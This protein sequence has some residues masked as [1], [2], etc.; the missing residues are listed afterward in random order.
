[1]RR[2]TLVS[3]FAGTAWAQIAGPMLGWVPDSAQIGPQIR[4]QIRPMYGL[5]GAGAVAGAIAS[6]HT[7]ALLA[8]SPRQDY[9]LATDA[10]SG[11]ALVV[12]PGTS[13]SPIAGV[14]AGADRM[15]ISPRGSTAALWFAATSHFE[16]VSG[17]PG[18][19]SVRE[20]DATFLGEPGAF[21]VSDD[22]GSLAGAWR[23]GVYTFG[24]DG[25]VS[26]VG[27][28][29]DVDAL[30]FYAG[31]SDLVYTSAARVLSVSNG[32]ASVLYES[33]AAGVIGPRRGAGRGLSPAAGIATS[34][35]NRWVV[36]ASRTGTV[37]AIDTSS[38]GATT[39]YDCG[40]APE[41]VFG[42]GGAVFRLTGAQ[43]NVKI[44]DAAAAMMF[45]VPPA[46]G[47]ITPVAHQIIGVISAI[48][49]VTIGGL[50]TS[51]GYKQQPGIT[52]SLAA[53][54]TTALTG[55]LTLTFASSVGGDD[56]MIQFANSAGGRTATFTIA[57]GSTQASFS[58]SSTIPV[59]TGTLAGKITLTVTSILSAG[60]DVTPNPQPTASITTSPTPPSIQTVTFTQTSGGL[61]VV[62]TGFSSSRDMS[63][64]LFQF[65]PSTN[66]TVAS[67]SGV[68]VQ[69]AAPF[70]AWYGTTTSNQ[71]GSEFMLTVPFTVQG[72]PADIVAVTVTLT[73]SK[74]TST[75]VSPQ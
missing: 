19:P 57:A 46:L 34:F 51:P 35:D 45:A 2:L 26:R 12:V 6:G 50:P 23:A 49:P 22:G 60:V 56:Q 61:T 31:R 70:T 67:Q 75:P 52:V 74:G 58:G 63:T 30:A 62:V 16:I 18:T 64:G 5:P 20:I 68:T 3:L 25:A 27:P 40:C 9:V 11:A 28:E 14:A 55:T 66:A 53:P 73:N 69:L 24:P 71:Y 43:V 29:G 17:L 48:P 8:V 47:A 13:A 72:N 10:D 1:M 33:D 59:E 39:A 7:L 54:F 42:L 41:G 38:A 32:T 15:A 65:A 4:P 37:L 44:F 36:R 21:A